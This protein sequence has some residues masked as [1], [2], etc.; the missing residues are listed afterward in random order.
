MSNE[1]TTITESLAK[2]A[3]RANELCNSV[4][5]QLSVINS[6]LTSE[7]QKMAA[8]TAELAAFTQAAVDE[9]KVKIDALVDNGFRSEIPFFRVTK[10]QELK[11]NGV[12][13]P[14]TKGTPTGFANRASQYECEIVAHTQHGVDPDQ[15][16][17][18]IQKMWSEVHHTIPKHNQPE[19][20]II[21]LTAKDVADYPTVLSK[22]YSI[23]QGALPQNGIFT[24][25][26]WVKVEQGEVHMGYPSSDGS[27]RLPNDNKW[28]ERMYSG[29]VLSGGAYYNFGPHFYLT[30]GASCLIALPGVVLGKVPEGRW[31]YFE[32][33][34]FEREQ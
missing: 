20:A 14:G 21:R 7:K 11:I 6:T 17:P 9:S 26:A 31:G 8:K 23:Y 15:K 12:L 30:K 10:N 13:T 33:P 3:T 16:D 1:H 27:T 19:F 32:R 29:S 5:E 34:V 25:G 4:D 18:E 22:C 24:F 2:V 28:H